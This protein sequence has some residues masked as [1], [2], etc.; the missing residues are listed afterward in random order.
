M[1]DRDP[2]HADKP[3]GEQS[4]ADRL[5]TLFATAHPAERGPYANAE[6]ARAVNV[7]ATYIG[8]LRS[9]TSTNPGY[10]LLKNLAQHFNVPVAYFFDADDRGEAREDIAFLGFLKEAGVR[11]VALRT[12]ASLDTDALDALI[13]VLKHLSGTQAGSRKKTQPRRPA[14]QSQDERSLS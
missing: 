2:S 10:E 4:F 11:Q 1:A 13:P 9:G 7:S 12:V 8:N 3:A 6:V 14:V 5:N